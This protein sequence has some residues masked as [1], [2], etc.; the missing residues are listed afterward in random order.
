MLRQLLSV[1]E[2]EFEHTLLLHRRVGRGGIHGF[3]RA[4]LRGVGKNDFPA[5][6]EKYEM[7]SWFTHATSL[8]DTCPAAVRVSEERPSAAAR[9]IGPEE[10]H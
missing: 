10:R 8:R 2:I 7:L 3:P 6:R 4:A 5:L 1:V 9:E